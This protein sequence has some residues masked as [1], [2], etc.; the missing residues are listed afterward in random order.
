[1]PRSF[2]RSCA[3]RSERWPQGAEIPAYSLRLDV[4]VYRAL[5]RLPALI[6]QALASASHLQWSSFLVQ[7]TFSRPL[8][9]R[10]EE[11]LD[12]EPLGRASVIKNQINRTE[13][14]L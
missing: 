2:A 10:E 9:A 14:H 3:V 12:G 13:I 6:A 1:M 11:I 5:E 8:L 4:K 7:T